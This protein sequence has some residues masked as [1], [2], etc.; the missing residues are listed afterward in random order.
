ADMTAYERCMAAGKDAQ[1]QQQ[2]AA[3][4]ALGFNGTPSFQFVRQTTGKSY[5]LAGA[6]PV[7]G[8]TR[9][10]DDLLAGKE[11]P[12]DV[13]A[14]TDKAQKIELPFWAKPEGLAP[15]PKRP[16]FT[17]AGD[18]YKGSPN[19]KLVIVEFGDFQCAACQRHA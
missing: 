6:Q 17:V 7:E 11:P 1:V 8:F 14:Q 19:A 2:V 9:W 10:I 16:G 5:T 15:D 18:R 3:G 12:K 13:E 4:Q